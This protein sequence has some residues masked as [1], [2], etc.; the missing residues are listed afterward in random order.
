M[1]RVLIEDE[2]RPLHPF[3]VSAEIKAVVEESAVDVDVR[4]RVCREKPLP[5]QVRLL[6]LTV[7]GPRAAV[8]HEPVVCLPVH[9]PL[10]GQSRER[11]EPHLPDP[12]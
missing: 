2:H 8:K 10:D 11:L 3:D 5:G 7:P 9:V 6:V 1:Y 4:G 12:L